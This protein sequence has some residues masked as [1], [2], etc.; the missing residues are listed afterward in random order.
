MHAHTRFRRLALQ[1]N[2]DHSLTRQDLV[3]VF[4]QVLRV[5]ARGRRL[6]LL[7]NLDYS[8]T[9]QVV[10]SA[11]FCSSAR[12]SRCSA[13]LRHLERTLASLVVREPRAPVG[14]SMRHPCPS[15]RNSKAAIRS[16]VCMQVRM[17]S[18]TTAGHANRGYAFVN[19]HDARSCVLAVENMHET[20]LCNR[21]LSVSFA[22][23]QASKRPQELSTRNPIG[24]EVGACSAAPACRALS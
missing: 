5:C 21:Q 7:D 13:P 6:A 18:G 4:S 20:V 17:P 19:Y 3:C 15:D 14:A 9:R 16:A 23:R 8:L 12:S 22:Q 1:G 11:C 24:S 2:L 10:S